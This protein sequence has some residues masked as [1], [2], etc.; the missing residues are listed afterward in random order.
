MKAV[1]KLFFVSSHLIN[2]ENVIKSEIEKSDDN[3]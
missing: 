3:I 1:P 2:I